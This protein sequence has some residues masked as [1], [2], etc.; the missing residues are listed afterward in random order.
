LVAWLFRA[1][2]ETSLD[3]R[4]LRVQ[5]DRDWYVEMA[6]SSAEP[7]AWLT[8]LAYFDAAEGD[9]ASARDTLADVMRDG[10]VPDTVNWHAMTELAEAAAILEDR[11]SAATLHAKLAPN[12]RLFSVVA[13]G[14]ICLGSTQY[15]VGRLAATLD[16]RDEAELRLRRAVTENRRIGARPRATIALQRLG[17]LR[18]DPELLR[19]AAAQAD[20][21]DMPG[22][23]ERSRAAA[24]AYAS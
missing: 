1:L 16:R 11:E 3:V 18:S 14:G 5:I 4:G 23:A 22:L 10:N 8:C 17:E 7:W 19:Q 6:G 20:A 21:L 24:H 13:R 15:A 2:N 9:H 12:A